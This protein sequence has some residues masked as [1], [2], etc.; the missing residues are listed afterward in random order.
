MITTWNGDER[1]LAGI[2]EV[3]LEKFNEVVDANNEEYDD[4]IFLSHIS[5]GN[6]Y[7]DFV[8]VQQIMESAYRF[9]AIAFFEI[10]SMDE[11]RNNTIHVEAKTIKFAI[12]TEGVNGG[13]IS[14]R[15]LSTL[16]EVLNTYYREIDPCIFKMDNENWSYYPPE[17][18]GSVEL[19]IAEL[20]IQ[21]TL[22]VRR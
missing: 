22:E 6:V 1:V 13:T 12:F 3:L 21:V 9:P 20:E 14:K 18:F 11:T 7:D 16:R 4:G 10:D 2:Q 5:E 8:S 15:Y 19:R 17:R